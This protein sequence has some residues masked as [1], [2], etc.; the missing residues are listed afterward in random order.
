MAVR[1]AL[2]AL[3]G[4]LY[5][6]GF[7]GFDLW[8]LA[9]VA[10]VPMLW[11]LDPRVELPYRHLVGLGLCFGFVTNVG[12]YY[13]IVNTLED[14]SGFPFA[15]CVLF[16]A[17]VWLYQSS[18]LLCFSLLYRRARHA[19]FGALSSAVAAMVFAE[20]AIPL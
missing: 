8:P 5:F 2:A 11:V 3:S 13:W 7:A 17:I 12:G 10:L 1:Y 19:G 15:V 14:F 4:A 20:W 18:A 6:L 9:F 16:A